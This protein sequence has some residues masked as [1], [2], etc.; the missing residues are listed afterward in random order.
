MT[1]LEDPRDVQQVRPYSRS[2]T[3]LRD[4]E[5]HYGLLVAYVGEKNHTLVP[6][7]YE[8]D[9]GAKLGRWVGIQR[10]RYKNLRYWT[11]EAGGQHLTVTP[12][13]VEQIRLLER[14]PGWSWKW[15][16]RYWM[17]A[18]RALKQFEKR[19]GDCDIPPGHVEPMELYA[20]FE[21]GSFV[22]EVRELYRG[23]HLPSRYSNELERRFSLDWGQ[24]ADDDST[25]E[26]PEAIR[27][28]RCIA[29]LMRF[30]KREGHIYVPPAHVEDPDGQAIELGQMLVDERER[31]AKGE[32]SPE[33][34]RRFQSLENWTWDQDE[35]N[36]HV[37]LN[38]LRE[39]FQVNPQA[40][41]PPGLL[42]PLGGDLGEWVREQRNL[43][44]SGG[45]PADRA[46]ALD[47]LADWRWGD[48]DEDFE[49]VVTL[50]DELVERTQHSLDLIKFIHNEFLPGV[51]Q[52]AIRTFIREY[53]VLAERIRDR[54][55]FLRA[56]REEVRKGR[57]AKDVAL[58]AV[59]QQLEQENSAATKLLKDVESYVNQH[60]LSASPQIIKGL[61]GKEAII[62][63]GLTAGPSQ[64][65]LSLV[66]EG[67]DPDEPKSLP[68]FG[69]YYAAEKIQGGGQC[70]LWIATHEDT[71]DV[72]AIK[73][74]VELGPEEAM[75]Q[76]ARLAREARALDRVESKY[77][78]GLVADG[79]IHPQPW[80]GLEYLEGMT[81]D[82]HRQ[83]VKF[84]PPTSLAVIGY[85]LAAALEAVHAVGL[86]HHDVKPENVVL[87]EDRGAVLIDLG[88]VLD[89][90]MVPLAGIDGTP[91]FI[92][93]EIL[94]GDSGTAKTDVWGWGA[95][96]FYAITG[97]EPYVE[98]D[99]SYISNL[100]GDQS[101]QMDR[102]LS[103]TDVRE[104][105]NNGAADL[106][107]DYVWCIA[108][109]LA[110][111]RTLDDG[112]VLFDLVDPSESG[113]SSA[114]D[115]GDPEEPSLSV[116]LPPETAEMIG[117]LNTHLLGKGVPTEQLPGRVEDLE[118]GKRATIIGM[119]RL[120]SSYKLEFVMAG[121]GTMAFG[122]QFSGFELP[123]QLG[124]LV[125]QA[126][127]DNPADRPPIEEIRR[128]LGEVAGVEVKV[129]DA[130]CSECGYWPG[131][132]ETVPKNRCPE[133]RQE[134]FWMD[135]G[136]FQASM[137]DWDDLND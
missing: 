96:L 40:D 81:L 101:L 74:P 104:L 27:G 89:E 77:V 49:E 7:D 34:V 19:E 35:S 38:T 16:Y 79:S 78:V 125:E 119:L 84:Q 136:D 108:G 110:G 50:A 63:R 105:L 57:K 62:A 52:D 68:K 39:F 87:V 53:Q 9:T 82:E 46:S 92:A 66:S 5:T 24:E 72:V 97:R 91:G 109:E 12:D 106:S 11:D 107:M 2:V 98:G 111:L 28:L 99:L 93:P 128:Q 26:N 18:I 134:T 33:F 102:V 73:T 113:S 61:L 3:N 22:S 124:D 21:L 17:D 80:I 122:T 137:A 118:D 112:T 67:E 132:D 85:E 60:Q 29:A 43:Y 103:V 42:D 117:D 133:C 14:I 120:D 115:I 75:R 6:S 1:N 100:L 45:L 37:R 64:T 36:F 25:H 130:V 88:L 116:Q 20:D 129:G 69:P 86:T 76:G 8:T 71:G 47:A 123:P 127:S 56:A 15:S 23:G 65:T 4:W 114:F 41:P 126:L 31:Y 135:P 13:H 10:R 44:R 121:F 95:T 70:E 83:G 94:A 55:A 131:T 32:L 48:L 30:N 59:V 54:S 51:H 90:T 58:P